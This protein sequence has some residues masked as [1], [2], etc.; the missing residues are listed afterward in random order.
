[1]QGARKRMAL[2]VDHNHNRWVA[3]RGCRGHVPCNFPRFRRPC[4]NW[5]APGP[6]DRTPRR[7]GAS[8]VCKRPPPSFSLSSS[9][10]PSQQ[11]QS[12]LVVRSRCPS[13]SPTCLSYRVA[14]VCVFLYGS[15]DRIIRRALREFLH[16]TL[17][18]KNVAAYSRRITSRAPCHDTSWSA[19]YRD[20]TSIQTIGGD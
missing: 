6:A 7:S 5:R 10:S 13:F 9:S 4:N 17:C 16:D 15:A 14:C 11:T 3:F 8:T 19:R 20:G 12:H 18:A 2:T 1:M